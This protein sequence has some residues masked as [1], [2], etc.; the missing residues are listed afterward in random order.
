MYVWFYQHYNRRRHRQMVS[1]LMRML[2]YHQ[3][4]YDMVLRPT[5][6]FGEPPVVNLLN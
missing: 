4:S 6:L 2:Y 5:T 3:T 1:D